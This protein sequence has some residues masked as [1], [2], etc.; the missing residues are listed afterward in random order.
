MFPQ[1][2]SCLVVLLDLPFCLLF[3][4]GA[5]TL[6]GS[7]SHV[8]QLNSQNFISRALPLSLAATQRIDFSFFSY[9][10]LDGSVPCV[11]LYNLCIQL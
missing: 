1:G 2:F 11:P 7:P 4:Y 8:I 9:R 5:L 3:I 10:Y 6:F